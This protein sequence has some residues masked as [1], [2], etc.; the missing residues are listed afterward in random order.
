MAFTKLTSTQKQFLESHLRGTG[1]ELS[2]AQAK[3]TYGIKNMRA[4]ISTMRNAGL[5]VRKTYNTAGR[6]AYSISRRDAAG[7]QG[8]IFS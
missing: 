2:S 3:Q 8:K 7:C 5:I 4:V 1:R 6:T